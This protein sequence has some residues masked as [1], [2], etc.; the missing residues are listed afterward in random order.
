MAREFAK[1][2]YRSKAWETTRAAFA[3]S[4]GWLC[5]DCLKEGRLVPGVVVHHVIP[6]SPENISDERISLG[7]GNLRLV[8]VDCHAK[9]HK[10]KVT[11]Y[12]ILPDGT[13]VV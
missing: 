3:A 13:V 8:C 11:R 12:D 2:F 9:L 6:L 7:W 10:R 4:K 5:E 1:G